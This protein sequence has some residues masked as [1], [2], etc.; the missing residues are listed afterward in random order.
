MNRILTIGLIALL[1]L[2]ATH[3]ASLGQAPAKASGVL[4]VLHA[5]QAVTLTDTAGGYRERRFMELCLAS[6]QRFVIDNTNPAWLDRSKYIEAAKAR[7]FSIVGYYFQSK[8]EDCL[9][10]N[11]S[12]PESERVPEVAIFSAAKKFELPS[13]SE[14]FEQL[15][16]VRLEDGRFVVEERQDEV[17]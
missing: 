17:R 8:I 14:G 13:L 9:R 10:R 16:Y 4:D 12:R 3:M 6:D 2:A 5:G 11:A 15:F 7:R 1:A